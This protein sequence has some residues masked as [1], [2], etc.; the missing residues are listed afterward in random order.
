[1]DEFVEFAAGFF[2]VEPGS[3]RLDTEYG[4]IE[5]WDSLAHMRLVLE[6]E[7]R[8]GVE[9]PLEDMGGIQ[10][11]ADLYSLVRGSDS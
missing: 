11:L 5:E 3:L 7:E 6:A 10:T 8:Y 1:M 9:I 2:G 4:S